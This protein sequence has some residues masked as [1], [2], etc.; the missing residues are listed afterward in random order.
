MV[1]PGLNRAKHSVK[2]PRI[3]RSQ[4][5]ASRFRF[6]AFEEKVLWGDLADLFQLV[7]TFSEARRS[8]SKHWRRITSMP[9]TSETANRIHQRRIPIAHA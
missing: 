9:F 4:Q 7:Y 2:H 6:S 1:S 8:P 5:G 3:M